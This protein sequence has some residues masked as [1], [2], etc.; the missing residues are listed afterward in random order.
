[1][2]SFDLNAP[3]GANSG[4]PSDAERIAADARAA[5]FG[6]V[7]ALLMASPRHSN[8][9]LAQ[10]QAFVAPAMALGQLAI[11][12]KQSGSSGGPDSAAAVWWAMVSPEVDERL[13]KSREP[14][15]ILAADEW[16]SGT[17][18]WIIETIGNGEVINELVRRLAEQTFPDKP[19]K[20]RAHLPDGRVAV[21]RIERKPPEGQQTKT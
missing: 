14:H 10:A 13:T 19:A 21:G 3:A 15:L 18:P 16:R 20:L 7:V 4:Q 11:L 5:A 2:S 6:R 8:M 17:Q 1:M 9:T 12:G